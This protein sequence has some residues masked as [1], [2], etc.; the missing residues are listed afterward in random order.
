MVT[1]KPVDTTSNTTIIEATKTPLK[2]IGKEPILSGN[3]LSSINSQ[4]NMNSPEAITGLTVGPIILIA[5]A[6]IIA[7]V[8][9]RRMKVNKG[10]KPQIKDILSK[11]S[12]TTSITQNNP[13]VVSH[14]PLFSQTNPLI[15]QSNALTDGRTMNKFLNTE[16]QK[17]AF[18]QVRVANIV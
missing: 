8:M 4:T 13:S 7:T 9:Y 6:A 3:E 16:R 10:K 15:N 17:V 14:N 2:P 18:G 5:L 12:N 1:E 11:N